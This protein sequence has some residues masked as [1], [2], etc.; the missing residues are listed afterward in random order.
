[1]VNIIG[2]FHICQKGEWKKSFTII[3]NFI[4]N[5]GLYDATTEIR[6][7]I[8]SDSGKLIP[9]YKFE[10]P[11]IKI[12]F[13]GDSTL[14]ERPTLI[15]MREQ[16]ETDKENTVYW[17]LHTKGLRHFNTSRESFVLDWIKLMLYWNIQKWKLA[18]EKLNSYD[19]Y[20]CNNISNIIYSGNFWWANINHIRKLPI[21]IESHYT[22]PEEW[23]LLNKPNLCEIYS[24][25]IQGKGHYEKNFPIEKYYY[26]KD[27]KK[28]LPDYFNFENYKILNNLPKDMKRKDAIDHYLNIGKYLKFS[29]ISE[30]ESNDLLPIFDID[31][32]RLNNS[33]LRHL[34]NNELIKHW[35]THGKFENRIFTNDKIPDDFDFDFYRNIYSDIASYNNEMIKCHWINYGKFEGRIYNLNVIKND[36]NCLFLA[37]NNNLL[38]LAKK[39]INNF[40]EEIISHLD[41]N[42]NSALILAI[43]KNYSDLANKIID[44]GYS[45]PCIINKQNNNALLLALALDQIDVVKNLIEKTDIKRIKNHKNNYNTSSL[46]IARSKGLTDILKLLEG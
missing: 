11:K 33:D 8:T 29:Y 12:I 22:A 37:I 5:Y 24:S 19:T 4:K 40:S 45:N 1:M 9:Y 32:Y 38:N 30:D 10:D 27:L 6:C 26:S 2:Y 17:Y 7:G 23:I 44:T 18:L 31:G 15:N 39:I 14:Y 46:D 28:V 16:S 21:N 13:I 41:E 25:G 43:N 3:F 36:K 20:G 34:N 35:N 42:N